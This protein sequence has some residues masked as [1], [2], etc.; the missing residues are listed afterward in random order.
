MT[1]PELKSE[2]KEVYSRISSPATIH[3]LVHKGAPP[4]RAFKVPRGLIINLKDGRSAA[5]PEW[6]VQDVA[7]FN[8]NILYNLEVLN[9]QDMGE[10]EEQALPSIS[11]NEQI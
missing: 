3:V 1:L 10:L 7:G 8:V 11:I 4:V 9:Y 6:V 5:F 2:L